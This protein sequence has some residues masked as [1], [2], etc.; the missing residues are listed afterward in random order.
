[1]SV[2]L[3]EGKTLEQLAN[4]KGVDIQT[5]QD[6]IQ[7]AHATEMRTQIEQAVTD[8]TITQE[9]ADWLLEGLDKGF[10]DGPGFGGPR[11]HGF[12]GGLMGQPSA[13]NNK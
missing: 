3:K 13:Q 4:E 11:G 9:K 12:G 10:L 7:A 6:A 2:T 1:M 5:V 8:G